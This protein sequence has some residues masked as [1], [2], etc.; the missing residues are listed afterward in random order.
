MVEDMRRSENGNEQTMRGTMSGAAA[1]ATIAS[2]S[3]TV[4]RKEEERREEGRERHALR[5]AQHS[6]EVMGA[7]GKMGDGGIKRRPWPFV[8]RRSDQWKTRAS[9]GT[10]S[11]T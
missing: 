8:P 10:P 11:L 9:H 2:H 3:C 1:T 5:R 6:G 4:E 7:E